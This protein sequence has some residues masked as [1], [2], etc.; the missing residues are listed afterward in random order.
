M[1]GAV[2]VPP[3]GLEPVGLPDSKTCFALAAAPNTAAI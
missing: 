3:D 2:V 1:L